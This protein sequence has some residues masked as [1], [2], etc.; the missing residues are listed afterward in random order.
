MSA[1][2]ILYVA[3]FISANKFKGEKNFTYGHRI[4]NSIKTSHYT[5][6]TLPRSD[7]NVQSNFLSFTCIENQNSKNIVCIKSKNVQQQLTEKWTHHIHW[8]ETKISAV[9]EWKDN[10]KECQK[11]T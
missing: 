9:F 7:F 1:S 3:A 6:N 11:S 2:A 8:L 4:S 5:L 10:E